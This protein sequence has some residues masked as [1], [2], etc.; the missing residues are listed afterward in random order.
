MARSSIAIPPAKPL[1]SYFHQRA[2]GLE[3][4]TG[5]QENFRNLLISPPT[6]RCPAGSRAGDAVWYFEPEKYPHMTASS[7][8]VS[9]IGTRGIDAPQN[10]R[11]AIQRLNLS[12]LLAPVGS[13]P[14]LS[15]LKQKAAML[16]RIADWLSGQGFAKF[17]EFP[18]SQLPDLWAYLGKNW[19]SD[20][21]WHILRKILWEMEQQRRRGFLNDTLPWADPFDPA[22]I[23]GSLPS[24]HRNPSPEFDAPIEPTR[25]QESEDGSWIPLSDEWLQAA[26]Y[27]WNFLLTHILPNLKR[28]G[29]DWSYL[30]GGA[31][32][33]TKAHACDL[34]TPLTEAR[35]KDLLNEKRREYLNSFTWV[36]ADGK[37][38]HC[39]PF[40]LN[41]ESR[42]PIL[43]TDLQRLIS[44]T[45]KSLYGLLLLLTAGRASEIRTLRRHGGLVELLDQELGLSVLHGRTFKLSGFGVGDD[46]DWPLPARVGDFIKDWI[47]FTDFT[48][49]NSHRIWVSWSAKRDASINYLVWPESLSKTFGLERLA[50]DVPV[51][52]HRFRKTMARL[53]VLCLVG[54]PMILMDIL[55]HD[56]LV[57]TLKY[58][59]ADP[60][61]REELSSSLQDLRH[62]IAVNVAEGLSD[63]GGPAAIT[64]KQMRDEYFKDIGISGNARSQRARARDF[65]EAQLADGNIDL[66]VIFAGI[67][68]IKPG[69]LPGRCSVH[70]PEP[71]VSRC[72]SA[73]P[74]FLALPPARTWT[75][76]TLEWL[77]SE[78]QDT[79]VQSKP[80]LLNY[81]RA[82]FVDQAKIFDDLRIE[83]AERA[84]KQ[85]LLPARL[86]SQLERSK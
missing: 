50:G 61:I 16:N 7:V 51:H 37:I 27:R 42:L 15:S 67:L 40:E 20:A 66:K 45:Q 69:D 26:G 4:L 14:D 47:A 5:N 9:Y 12:V 53:A 28:I 44:C 80:L 25:D 78:L 22:A 23:T 2:I 64:L 35:K 73:C 71:D 58:I 21:N 3:V 84:L 24:F 86:Q 77:I 43:W 55:G 11:T 49:E 70:T 36:D 29:A 63:A 57:T 1:A 52:A 60:H 19:K 41:G 31:A 34:G 75:R 68:C 65:A 13:Q 33:R 10:F 6:A 62:E 83:Y 48:H 46:K 81:Y 59:F 30:N 82:S 72:E 8:C 18:V 79:E 85:D 17:A 76:T 54:A 74:Y 56:S 32:A 39:L 38:L